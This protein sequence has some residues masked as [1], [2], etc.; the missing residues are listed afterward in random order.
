MGLASGVGLLASFPCMTLEVGGGGGVRGAMRIATSL[1][2][3]YQESGPHKP[4][5]YTEHT[6]IAQDFAPDDFSS[7]LVLSRSQIPART[8]L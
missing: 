3:F 5:G 7:G 4:A 6:A 1:T 8:K 2:F